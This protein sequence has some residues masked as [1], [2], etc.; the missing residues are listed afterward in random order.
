[1][2]NRWFV[3]LGKQFAENRKMRREKGRMEAALADEIEHIAKQSKA[4]FRAVHHYKQKLIG[5]AQSALHY[6]AQNLAHIPGPIV[7]DPAEWA[8][9]GYLGLFFSNGESIRK[10]LQASKSLQS[11]FKEEDKPNAMGLLTADW[12]QKTFLGIDQDGEIVRRDVPQTAYYFEHH[13]LSE[14]YAR[15]SETREQLV[16]RILAALVAHLVMKVKGLQDWCANLEK[17]R[18]ILELFVQNAANT[19]VTAGNPANATRVNEAKQMLADLAHKERTLRTQIGDPES[20]LEQVA[21]M[22]SNPQALFGVQPIT[23]RLNRLGIQVNHQSKGSAIDVHLAKY[24][25]VDQPQKTAL[26]VQVDRFM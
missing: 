8:P 20:Q 14:I 15:L 16:N 2:E 22:L 19:E 1:M 23:L 26:W 3:K 18:G 10:V 24:N 5:P 6:I 4:D 25:L 12:K 7:L 21:Q 13:N 9:D 11:F 17:E